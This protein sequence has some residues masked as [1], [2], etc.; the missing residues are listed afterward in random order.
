MLQ[1]SI[2]FSGI[3]ANYFQVKCIFILSWLEFIPDDF[4]KTY[5][6]CRKCPKKFWRPFPPN[7][8]VSCDKKRLFGLFLGILNIP[9]NN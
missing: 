6:S 1:A 7:I 3:P 2:I 8:L 9:E 4:P 5:K